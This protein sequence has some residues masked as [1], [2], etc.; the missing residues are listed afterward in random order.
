M[1]GVTHPADTPVDI[2]ASSKVVLKVGYSVFFD[3]HVDANKEA[4]DSTTTPATFCGGNFN[5][6]VHMCCF[7]FSVDQ[8][9]S[10]QT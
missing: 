3:K 6:F 7:K 4:K 9:F 1:N 10:S 2:D 5:A 8:P